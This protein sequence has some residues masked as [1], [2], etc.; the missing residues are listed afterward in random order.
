MATIEDYRAKARERGQR[1]RER[2]AK[3]GEVRVSINLP[4]ALLRK[5][6]AARGTA[7]RSAVVR[8]ALEEW[9]RSPALPASPAPAA[10]PAPPARKTRRP[11]RIT[12]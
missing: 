10:P 2:Q 12:A 7:G 5:L 1:H 11:R 8:H 9:L 3:A 4:A 6:D